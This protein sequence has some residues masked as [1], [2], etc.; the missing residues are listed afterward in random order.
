MSH[1]TDTRPPLSKRLESLGLTLGEF[2]T[3]TLEVSPAEP[4]TDFVAGVE[5]KEESISGANQLVLARRPSIDISLKAN[6]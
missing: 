5:E 1:P 2:V 6:V 3:K 4:A